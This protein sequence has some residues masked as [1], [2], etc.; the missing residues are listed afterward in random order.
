MPNLLSHPGAPSHL[1]IITT[2]GDVV[3]IS[4]LQVRKLGLREI[5]I[6]LRSQSAKLDTKSKEGLRKTIVKIKSRE[7]GLPVTYINH[8]PLEGF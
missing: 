5:I 2:P 6:C 8:V 7:L 3:I 1:I 4:I